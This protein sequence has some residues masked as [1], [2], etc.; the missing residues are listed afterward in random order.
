[1]DPSLLNHTNMPRWCCPVIDVQ[2][3]IRLTKKGIDGQSH[4]W[5]LYH[6]LG[7]IYWQQGDYATAAEAYGTGG[8]IPGAPAWMEAMKAKMLAEGGSRSTAREI[9]T[10]MY[11]RVNRRASQRDGAQLRLCNWIHWT[12]EMRCERLLQTYKTRSGSCPANWSEFEPIF[13]ALRTSVDQSGAPLD[14][15][16][17]PYVFGKRRAMW[18]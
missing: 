13:R 16:G 8:Q 11:G 1:M 14:P 17:T 3:A 9:Y 4:A 7:Y 2:Q 10:R 15:A 5:K 6:H 18:N 12:N